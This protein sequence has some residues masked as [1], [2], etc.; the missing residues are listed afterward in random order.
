MKNIVDSNYQTGLEIAII[1]MSGCFPGAKNIEEFWHNLRDGIESIHRFTDQELKDLG[2]D[3]ALFNNPNYVKAQG[4]VKDID[5]FDASFF[6]ISPREAEVMDPSMRFFLEHSWKALE[7]AGYSSEVYKK[8]IGVYAGTGFGSYLLNIYSNYEFLASVGDKQIEKGTSASYVTTLTSYKLNLQGPSY[9]VQTTCSSS[10][11]AIHLACQSLLSGECNI[12][13]AGG[14]SI[15]TAD[16]YLY[17]EGGIE[18]PDGHCRAFDAKAGG[19]VRGRGLGLVVLKRLE[20]A[21]GD[22][23]YIHAV[24]KG[25]AINN[26]GS[27]KVSFTAPSVNGQ[28][29]VIRAAQIMA[30]VEPDTIS[31]IEAHGTGTTLGDPI[32]ISALTQA[33]RAKTQKKGFCG[34]GSVKTNIGHLDSAAGVA[35]LIKT[36]LALKHKK[37]PPSLNFEEP[38]PQIDFANSPFYVNHKLS[39]WK[40]NDTPRRAGVSSFGFGG[41]NAH[42]ILEEA[43]LIK[44]SSSSRS[45]QLLLLSAKTNTALENVTENLTDYLLKHP[46]LNLADVAHTLQVG[47]WNLNHRRM[48]VCQDQEDAIKA[49][50]DP[51][52]VFTHYQEPCN[53]PI[54]FMFSG[55]GS[56]YVNMGRELYENETVFREQIDYCCELLKPH[57]EL[58][59]RTILYPSEEKAQQATQKLQQTAI[60]QPALFVI[61]YALAKLWMTWGVY[62]EMMIGHSIGEY[63]AAT[64]AGV[65]SLE[66]ALTIVATR[67]KLM[68]QLPGGAML[69]IALPQTEVQQFLEKEIFLA[70]SNT[71]SSCVVS[72]TTEAIDQLQQEV[73]QINVSCRRLH[74][75]HA[76]HSQMMEP[77]IDTFVQFLQKVKL[78]PPKIPFVSNVSGTW[79]KAVQATDP[80]YWAKHLRQPV[81]FCEGI[82]E[83]SK[84][85]DRLFLEVGPGRTLSTFVKQHQKEE[86]LV[87]TSIR[88]PREQQSD[89]AFLLNSLGKLWLF[90]VK[91]D[92]SGFYINEHRHRIPLP[93]YPFE[94]KRYWIEVNRN[95]TLAKMSEAS[96]GKKPDIA[97]WFYVPRWKESI[98]L[99]FFQKEKFLEEKLCWLVFAD[100]YGVGAEVA[101]RLKQQEQDV[102]IVK[103]ADSFA[104]INDYTYT[105][106]PQQR[107]NYDTLLQALQEQNWIPQGIAHFWSVT[108]N[109]ALSNQKQDKKAQLELRYQFFED[110]QNLGFYSLLFLA[111][112]L[113]QQNIIEPIKLMVITSNVHDIT[114]SENLYP[115]KVT[116]LSPCKVIPQEYPNI[117]CYCFDIVLEDSGYKS[118]QK[119]IDYLLAEFKTQPNDNVISYRGNHRWVQTYEPIHLDKNFA[120][121]TRLREKGVYLIT[122]GLGNVGLVLAEYLARTVQAKLILIGRKGFPEKHQWF[123]WLE[124]HN[125]EDNISCKIR[126][127]QE[128]EAFGGE[129]L[130]ISADV[131]NEQQ[132]HESIAIANKKFGNIN[133]VIYAAGNAKDAHCAITETSKAEAQSQFHPKVYGLFVLEKVVRGQELDF[134]QLTSSL[135]SVL[136]GLGFISYSAANIFMDAFVHNYNQKNS[137]PWSSVNWDDWGIEQNQHNTGVMETFSKYSMTSKAGIDSFVRLLSLYQVPQ[138]IVSTGD[139]QT[140]IE[141]WI[142][143]ESLQTRKFSNNEDFFTK[144]QRPNLHTVYIPPRNQIE[145]KIAKIWQ[146]VLGITEVGIDDNFFELGGDSLI[147]TCVMSQIR[148]VFGVELPL[149]YLF[150]KPTIAELAEEIEKAKHTDLGL[151]LPLIKRIDPGTELPL[152]F[153]QQRLWFL[154]QL[155][156]NSSSYNIPAAVRLQG[157]LNHKALEQSFN[158]IV[159][160]HEALRTNFQA[161]EGQAVA[162]ISEDLLLTLPI[163]DISEL[164]ASQ[165]E[166]EIKEQARQEAQQLFDLA[167]DNLIRLKLFRLGEQEHIVLLTMHHIVSDAWSTG[168][169]IEELAALYPAFC[170][171]KPSP[172]SELPIQYADFAVWQR[173]W[174]QGKVLQTQLDYWK[175]QLGNTHP[176]LTLP[177]PPN[178]SNVESSKGAK[179][180]FILSKELTEA[181]N[182]LNRQE[183]VTLFMTLLVVFQVLLHCFTGTQD[184]RVGSPIAN[185]NRVEIEKLIGFFINTLVLRID[186]SGNPTFRELLMLPASSHFRS[187]CSPRLT[188]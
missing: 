112:A 24:I 115:E 110:C 81:R 27:D 130:V 80:N 10:L 48:L 58:D 142:K 175:K 92:W 149:R 65:F 19:T 143:L 12:A 84:T 53:R 39:E 23:D 132:M 41:T 158:E 95:A 56:Q 128:I 120:S 166:A 111:Q 184:I 54:V 20:E 168:V 178:P 154:T 102:I 28:A 37:I 146:Q 176:R 164:P 137:C 89:V 113:G 40:T 148:Q 161:L 6:D 124:T 66:D 156:P 163:L 119:H 21:I 31:Y 85:P 3:A 98:P 75:S 7:D 188:F 86:Y 33:F 169:L 129:V 182:L 87:L 74:T 5:L 1:G 104:K 68:Q 177:K 62:P 76:F 71:P 141:Q 147:A 47:R 4:I 160:R 159:R 107:D 135:A 38:S 106:N 78:N 138:V 96:S 25:S 139:L 99:E 91:V 51:Q 14:V 26:D 152:S 145:Q 140:R 69:S 186:L 42:V 61:E 30:E 44:P 13:L 55:Q 185:R 18:S 88:H 57:L 157:E 59:L 29:K 134:C 155:E 105:I 103:I 36:V 133:G 122:G 136:G 63:V 90:G 109:D 73:Q 153:A 2:V 70:A 173:Q 179:Q 97:D 126:K 9:A 162:V 43:P 35:S 127:V 116:V 171:G 50:Q 34:I 22:G 123:Q 144:H 150:E 16:G 93:T 183:G 64:L 118:S 46:D 17:Q 101:E 79:I 15:S 125:R 165:Q 114:G 131:A 187:L 174:L 181:I 72:G 67:G 11:V 94:R 170:A 117:S 32:E 60:T 108:P 180:S 77:I 82:I 8:P 167:S 83:L 151:E 45:W 100:T 121:K 52:T 49:L 172:L